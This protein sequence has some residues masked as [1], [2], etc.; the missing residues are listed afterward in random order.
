MNA[1]IIAVGSELL[2]PEKVDTNSLYLTQHLNDLGIEVVAKCIIGD[3]R[4]RLTNEIRSSSSRSELVLLAWRP[5]PHRRRRHP[6]R[7]RRRPRP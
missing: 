4:T 5:R 6:R 1:E 7:L 2:T 3:D